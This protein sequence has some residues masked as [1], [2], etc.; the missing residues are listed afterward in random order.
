MITN[1]SY[2]PATEIC[3]RWPELYPIWQEHFPHSWWMDIPESVADTLDVKYL[4]QLLQNVGGKF[5][6]SIALREDLTR[7]V[8]IACVNH[9]NWVVPHTIANNPATPPDILAILAV[10]DRDLV[11]HRVAMNANTPPETLAMLANDPDEWVKHETLKNPKTPRD[12]IT[13]AYQ[14]RDGFT[15]GLPLAIAGNPNTAGWVIEELR[16]HWNDNIRRAARNNG[17][18]K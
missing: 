4:P 14:T 7:E 9:P 17:G 13:K 1:P 11:R 5:A 12:S 18:I 3:R 15:L 16:Q 10:H 8:I 6:R 2:L